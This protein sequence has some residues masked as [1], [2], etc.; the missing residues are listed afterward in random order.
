MLA[1]VRRV[2]EGRDFYF[3]VN[4]AGAEFD[5]A[6]S[7]KGRGRP[8]RWDAKS[9]KIVPL[10]WY[11]D[12][13]GRVKVRLALMPDESMF[14]SFREPAGDERPKAAWDG[15]VV[16]LAAV[17]IVSARYEARDDA[18]LGLDVT[19]N[20]RGIISRG[21]LDFKVSNATLGVRD[22]APNYYKVLKVEWLADGQAR[23]KDFQEHG[24]ASLK[25][26]RASRKPTPPVMP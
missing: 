5:G 18:K 23:R 3:V 2:I 7:F 10:P 22:P 6:V 25:E 8:E 16:E 26:M 20:L 9:G 15:P 12:E 24:A 14:V 21:E 1:A 19:D 11:A 4:G 13:D 17:K